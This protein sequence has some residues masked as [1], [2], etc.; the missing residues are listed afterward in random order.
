MLLRSFDGSFEYSAIGC[1]EG[2]FNQSI[3]LLVVKK[4]YLQQCVGTEMSD[5]YLGAM[6]SHSCE[7]LKKFI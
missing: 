4:A 2:L 3:L 7:C 1:E 6:K 5:T